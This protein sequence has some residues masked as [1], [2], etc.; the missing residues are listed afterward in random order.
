MSRD[1][2]IDTTYLKNYNDSL[3]ASDSVLPD[4]VVDTV[5]GDTIVVPKKVSFTL[6]VD[7]MQF[8]EEVTNQFLAV[9]E[10]I[11]R[12]KLM[13]A[14]TRP[15]YD[16]VSLRPMNFDSTDNM[17][18]TETSMHNDTLVY[19]I[20][21]STLYNLDTLKFTFEYTIL[22]SLKN[23]TRRTDTLTMRY[24]EEKE[25]PAQGRRGKKDEDKKVKEDG[26]YLKLTLNI[27]NNGRIDLNRNISVTTETP[28]FKVVDSLI[29][30]FTFVDSVE[31][32]KRLQRVH[33]SMDFRKF[34]FTNKWEE[35]TP[36]RLYIEPGAFT[37]IYQK[38]N[39][40]IDI[41][42]SSEKLENYGILLLTLN[43]IHEPTIVQLTDTKDNVLVERS[44]EN[45]GKFNF[46]Y[47]KPATYRIKLIFDTNKNGK[48]DT[49]NYLKKFS[50]KKL[51]IIRELLK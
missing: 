26:N 19:W 46:E 41:S 23:F 36:Y 18:L 48:W 6:H 42:F 40:T 45:D 13:F 34:T 22:D 21:D 30:F 3:F 9:K 17:F 47:L 29:H 10:R 27:R 43:G 11:G 37:D 44:I 25:K 51:C 16:S 50:P 39:D 15:L 4:F 31:V 33:D 28:V 49:G 8:Q 14:F 1:I 7:F 32:S 38:S 20:T 24:R 5:S 2:L 35:G 12:E